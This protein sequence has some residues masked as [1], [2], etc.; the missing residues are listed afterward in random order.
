MRRPLPIAIG[1]T[2]RVGG[3]AFFLGLAIYVLVNHQ[4]MGVRG[5]IAR[6]M[7]PS[8]RDDAL[9][10][11]LRRA[12][13]D[14]VQGLIWDP[15]FWKSY[16]WAPFTTMV[17]TPS[18]LCLD[19]TGSAMP[20]VSE[21]LVFFDADGEL[22]GAPVKWKHLFPLPEEFGQCVVQFVDTTDPKFLIMR[23]DRAL[24]PT[25]SGAPYTYEFYYRIYRLS[26]EESP[27][28]L[29]IIVPYNASA[30]VVLSM[31]VEPDRHERTTL[32]LVPYGT[33]V[34]TVGTAIATFVWDSEH[35]RFIEP[36]PDPQGRWRVV[37]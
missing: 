14:G 31:Q 37:E 8:E 17:P 34:K 19:A 25:T 33:A 22:A 7:I 26:R 30:A 9:A 10:V 36:P 13:L 3:W 21:L 18:Y 16:Y 2:A 28:V 20:G 6:L 11:L 12:G 24:P 5:Q 32:Q 4:G 29:T 23:D 35:Q 15:G 1:W 27:S